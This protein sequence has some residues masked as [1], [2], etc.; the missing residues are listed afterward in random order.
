MDEIRIPLK[1]FSIYRLNIVSHDNKNGIE[2]QLHAKI[3]DIDPDTL[4][5][6][7]NNEFVPTAL[8]GELSSIDDEQ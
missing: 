3:D 5:R 2:F 6:I 1:N 4:D 7:E 8:I